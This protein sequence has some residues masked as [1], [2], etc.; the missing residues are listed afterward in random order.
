[1]NDTH[2]TI[3]ALLKKRMAEKTG[4]ER[5][6]MGCDMYDTAKQIVVSSILHE[7]PAANTDFVRQNVFLRFYGD[8]FPPKQRGKIMAWLSKSHAKK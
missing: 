8:E 6:L 4:E 3:A 7:H 2:P 1:M 5:F